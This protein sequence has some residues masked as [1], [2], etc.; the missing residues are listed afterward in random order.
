MC[1]LMREHIF[2]PG[3]LCLWVLAAVALAAVTLVVG[4][5]TSI[6]TAQAQEPKPTPTPESGSVSP[7]PGGCWNG[8]LSADPVFCYFLEEAQRVGE[9]DIVAIYEA[10]GGGPLFV[11]LRQTETV[12]DE[13]GTF[14]REKAH[15]YLEGGEGRDTYGV[16]ECDDFTG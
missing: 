7:P 12:S 4:F 16:H 14:F 13:V 9:I 15:V 3:A 11:Y 10:P 6:S 1:F 8:V 5:H 2:R